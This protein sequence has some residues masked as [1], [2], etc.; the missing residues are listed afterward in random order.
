L[1]EYIEESIATQNIERPELLIATKGS[2]PII[3]NTLEICAAA[4]SR[5]YPVYLLKPNEPVPSFD[6]KGGAIVS[7]SYIK[8][9]IAEFV[10]P[11][12]RQRIISAW[13]R[14]DF[15][16]A[17]VWLEA[18]EDRY[19]AIY[20]LAGKLALVSNGELTKGLQE[21]RNSWI[22]S[23]TTTAIADNEQLEL[24][25]NLISSI[26][27]PS[28][29]IEDKFQPAWE[30][31]LTIELM[32]ERGNYTNA[33]ML[34][35]Q[36]LELVLSIRAN[37]EKW[38]QKGFVTY[39]NPDDKNIT[40]GGLILGWTNCEKIGKDAPKDKLL[41]SIVKLRNHLVHDGKPIDRQILCNLWKI[42]LTDANSH[43]LIQSMIQTLELVG[44]KNCQY[45]QTLLLRSLYQWG[46]DIL[47]A[48]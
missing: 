31:T 20:Q 24:W 35:A 29:R 42:P 4:L 39:K 30:Q 26:L 43:K 11:L 3:S 19:K 33:F 38:I 5:Q 45:P 1:F 27:S 44:G 13:S 48:R 2:A 47:T 21:L 25:K 8:Q 34:F 40:L 41:R 9:S 23:K 7:T 17:R 18:H 15:S 10:W 32:L 12:E 16:E 14:G 37:A 46:L 22:N 6:E 36:Q 28:D